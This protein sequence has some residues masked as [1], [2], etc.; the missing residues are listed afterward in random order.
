MFIARGRHISGTPGGK[1]DAKKKEERELKDVQWVPFEEALERLEA[2]KN[3]RWR[4][5]LEDSKRTELIYRC[6]SKSCR[7]RRAV[8]HASELRTATPCIPS[9]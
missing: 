4:Y 8:D 3:P 2:R 9:V 7:Q 1:K 5:A 6:W